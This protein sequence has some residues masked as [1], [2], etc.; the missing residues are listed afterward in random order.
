MNV[1][2]TDEAAI[3]YLSERDPV[4]KNIMEQIGPIERPGRGELFPALLRQI[5][6]QQV[7]MKAAR[8]VWG[9][10]EE[11]VGQVTPER[12]LAHSAEEI[13]KC[14]LSFRKVAYIQSTASDIAEGRV[15]LDRLA[16]ME[17]EDVIKTLSSLKGIGKWTAEMLLLFSMERPN[18]LSYDDLGIQRGMRMAY[19]QEKITKA[20]FE[21]CRKRY[22]PY[23]TT[24]SLYIWEVAAGAIPEMKDPALFQN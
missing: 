9:R 3:T 19:Q 23:G 14:G 2:K 24:A 7:S 15:D 5:V 16:Y 1:V 4:L 22:S 13:Q 17:D 18:V 21:A 11:L 12:V 10:F 6:G 8:T 20:F